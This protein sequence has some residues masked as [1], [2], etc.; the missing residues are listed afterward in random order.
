MKVLLNERMDA[1]KLKVLI[2]IFG[3]GGT[4]VNK[5][6]TKRYNKEL[7]QLFFAQ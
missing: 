1:F 5:N 6:W 3:G 4:K 2:I 7:M